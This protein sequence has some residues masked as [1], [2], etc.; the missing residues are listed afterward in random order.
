MTKFNVTIEYRNKQTGDT[1][2]VELPNMLAE[3]VTSLPP[4]GSR[5]GTVEVF[6]IRIRQVQ[7]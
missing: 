3:Q 2:A 6:F 5:S 7:G 4:V 1:F